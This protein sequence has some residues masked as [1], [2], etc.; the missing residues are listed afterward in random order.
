M[1]G[2]MTCEDFDLQGTEFFWLNMNEKADLKSVEASFQAVAE[3]K[4]GETST[5]HGVGE[6]KAYR[7][8][9]RMT[10]TEDVRKAIEMRADDMSGASALC[11]W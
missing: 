3:R 9:A 4:A 11:P 10:A 1:P 7:P 6:V 5:T 2:G 8:F